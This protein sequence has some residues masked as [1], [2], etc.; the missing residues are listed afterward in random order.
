MDTFGY[1]RGMD[2]NTW[3][4]LPLMDWKSFRVTMSCKFCYCYWSLYSFLFEFVALRTFILS[5]DLLLSCRN[6]TYLNPPHHTHIPELPK[7]VIPPQKV[8]DGRFTPKI[9]LK[10]HVCE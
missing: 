1:V 7:G 10:N 4:L 9:A 2:G 3:F 6:V 8:H 5:A